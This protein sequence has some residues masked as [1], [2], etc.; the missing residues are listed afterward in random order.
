ML[1]KRRLYVHLSKDQE[2]AVKVGSRHGNPVLYHIRAKQ[3]HDDGY[4]FYLSANCVWLTKEVPCK[5][6]EKFEVP[7]TEKTAVVK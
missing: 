3:M 2:S 5:Y 4:K 1:P 7:L 6:L